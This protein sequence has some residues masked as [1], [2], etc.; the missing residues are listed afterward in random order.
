MTSSNQPFFSNRSYDALKY[1]ALV[2][3]PAL[4]TLY[5][6]LS[7]IWELL[8]GIQV[9]G[10]ITAVDTFLGVLLNLSN[11][12]YLNSPEAYHGTVTVTD[13]PELQAREVH[14]DV[15]EDRLAEGI[16]SNKV[17]SLKVVKK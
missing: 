2:V 15:P 6:A 13:N 7:Q 1:I 4:G 8:Y 12:A 5:F 11:K 10:T 14:L 16:D 9:V 17:I 3:L